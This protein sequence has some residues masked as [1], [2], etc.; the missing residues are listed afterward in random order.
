MRTTP[1][2]PNGNFKKRTFINNRRSNFRPRTPNTPVT[3]NHSRLA[4]H[5]QEQ[6]G[7]G[8]TTAIKS[9]RSDYKSH[10]Q[11]RRKP[12]TSPALSHRMTVTNE[13]NP[14]I[15]PIIDEDTVRIITVSGVEEI[16]RNMNIIETKDDILLLMLVS[17]LF[18]KKVMPLALIIFCPILNI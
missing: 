15:P 7:T 16:G 13:K 11:N 17:N 8:T 4:S 3:N 5:G 9:K 10:K 2:E 14:I 12:M 1:T 18:P 6:T